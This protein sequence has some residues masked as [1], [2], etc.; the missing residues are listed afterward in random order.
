[1]SQSATDNSKLQPCSRWRMRT[2]RGPPC[3]A[4]HLLPDG[5]EPD[6]GARGQCALRE[7]GSRTQTHMKPLKREWTLSDSKKVMWVSHAAVASKHQDRY[8][9]GQLQKYPSGS[10]NGSQDHSKAPHLPGPEHTRAVQCRVLRD[11]HRGSWLRFR[12]RPKTG[13]AADCP[14]PYSSHPVLGLALV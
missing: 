3:P 7:D 1:M 14:L 2:V 5:Q 13:E 8:P 6:P 9:A 11:P 12:G 4:A 10:R